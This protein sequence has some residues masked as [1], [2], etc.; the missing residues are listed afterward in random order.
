ME[1]LHG[2]SERTEKMPC[3]VSGILVYSKHS[4]TSNPLYLTEEEEPAPDCVSHRGL[5]KVLG[6]SGFPNGMP[7]L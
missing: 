4:V 1:V 6:A 7:V 2:P 5:G 3:V